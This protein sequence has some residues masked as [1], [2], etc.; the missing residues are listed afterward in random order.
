MS[1][2]F[3][4]RDLAVG[5]LYAGAL[6]ELAEK[7][8]VAES[9]LEE[10]AG[11]EEVL[12]RDPKV[13]GALSS[14]LVDTDLR[15]KMVETTFR[16]RA[17]DLVVNTLQVM[18]QKGRL[19]L[20]RALIAGYRLEFEALRGITEVDVVVAEPLSDEQRARAQKTAEDWTGGKV[21]LVEIVDP[22]IIGGMIFRAGDRKLN[23]SVSRELDIMAGRLLERASEQ[24]QN[25]TSA[26]S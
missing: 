10:L 12:D 19:G 24:I 11:I 14:P 18:N 5:R 25:L 23:R 17:S 4:E 2:R 21:R 6:L 3:D 16:G 20:L 7:D 15:R 9:V 8:S 22:E 26:E 1:K 13:E